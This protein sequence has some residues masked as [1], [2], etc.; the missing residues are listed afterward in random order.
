MPWYWPFEND[1][2]SLETYS[3]HNPSMIEGISDD[4]ILL[5][6]LTIS[7]IGVSIYYSR[8][9]RNTTIHA[10]NRQNVEAFRERT[11]QNSRADVT[12]ETSSYIRRPRHDTCPICLTDSSV[13]SV[14]TNCG[15]LFCGQCIITYWKYQMNWMSGMHCPVCRQSITVLLRCFADDETT[16]DNDIRETV[17]TNVRDFN[18]RFSGAPRTFREY[19]YDIPVLIPHIIRQMFTVQNL[20]WTY[21]LRIILILFTVIAY[22][23]SPLD[24]LPESVLGFLGFFDDLLVTF[25]AA[26]NKTGIIKRQTQSMVL[27]SDDID[28]NPE[29][30]STT[31]YFEGMLINFRPLLLTD[32]K[33]LAHFLENLGSQ[34]RKFSTR[35]GYDLNEARDLCFAINRYDKLRL[36]ALINHETIIALFEFSL[37]IVENEYKRFSEKYGIILNEVT[38]MRFGP[39][40]S[41]QYQNRHFGCCLFEKVKPMCK[42]MGKERLILWVVFLL[43]INVL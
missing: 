12:D 1:S 2:M 16:A 31:D 20:A 39:C 15:H 26:L 10:D 29:L 32:E 19:I 25:C 21:R 35:N 37:S 33:K 5:V 17:I 18:R 11:Q 8:R 3:I 6:L 43:I 38:D 23:L 14:E 42:L 24:I 34:T 4:T 22:V 36:V 28:K 41:D 27:T 30:I 9:Q 40:I 7:L 13:L